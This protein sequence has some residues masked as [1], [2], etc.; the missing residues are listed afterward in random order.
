[1][2]K[3]PT[4][5]EIYEFLIDSIKNHPEEWVPRKLTHSGRGIRHDE[6]SI[7]VFEDGNIHLPGRITL[8]W[9][10]R[11]RL[12]GLALKLYLEKTGISINQKQLRKEKTRT[13]FAEKMLN[14]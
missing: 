8:G 6:K 3:S 5:K 13:K 11:H 12:G 7:Y 4:D 2:N 10:K 9:W 1:M 14:W